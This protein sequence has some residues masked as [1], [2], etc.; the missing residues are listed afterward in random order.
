MSHT[1]RFVSASMLVSCLAVGISGCSYIQSLTSDPEDAGVSADNA[2]APAMK[3]RA[4]SNEE[5]ELKQAKL[6]ARVDALE[7]ELMRQKQRFAV[8]EKGL[9]LGIIPE[10]L[11]SDKETPPT[12]STLPMSPEEAVPPRAAALPPAKAPIKMK[13]K[14]KPRDGDDPAAERDETESGS[15]GATTGDAGWNRAKGFL[16]AG[17]YPR[18]VIAYRDFI[19]DNPAD[20]RVSEARYKIGL[21]WSRAGDL[22]QARDEL[23]AFLRDNPDSEAFKDRPGS[24]LSAEAALELAR[25][26]ESL[27]LR[28]RAVEGY[29][30]VIANHPDEPVGQ[31]AKE[32]L[33]NIEKAL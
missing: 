26:E 30:R 22:S 33:A 17:N 3:P 7:S 23:M 21:S 11:R 19:R 25:V 8:L 20:P 10:E 29:Q 24:K 32:L 31:R 18:A 4:A 28:D 6:W 13:V 14:V 16:E 27:G 5:L 9:M 2:S 15:S 1:L 12:S